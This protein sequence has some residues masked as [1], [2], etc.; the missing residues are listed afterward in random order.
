MRWS[1]RAKDPEFVALREEWYARAAA[2]GFQDIESFL[3][4][5]GEPGPLL[6]GPS[7]GDL[8]RGLYRPDK[9]DYYTWA[10]HWAFSLP[11][12]SDRHIWRLHA[13]GCS[14]ATIRAAIGHRY[15]GVGPSRIARVIS[16]E[17][18]R[19]RA[20]AD[21]S[22]DTPIPDDEA[23]SIAL[24]M[25]EATRPVW[26]TDPARGATSRGRVKRRER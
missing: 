5:T 16:R 26:Y 11:P 21:A 13:A 17:R 10:R 23:D 9:E 18:A 25:A 1:D 2:T 12:T 8:A 15:A 20:A 22:W 7:P 24:A 4:V 3:R 19:M 6:A 14:M